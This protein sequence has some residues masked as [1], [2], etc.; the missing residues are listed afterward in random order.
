MKRAAIAIAILLSASLLEAQPRQARGESRFG[1]RDVLSKIG[2]NPRP[3]ACNYA[4]S[5]S[6]STTV[7]GMAS[8]CNDG[9]YWFDF[10]TFRA[11]STRVTA[12][13]TTGNWA[14]PLVV[15]IQLR[16]TGEIVEINYDYGSV[17]T[18]ANVTPGTDYVVSVGFLRERYSASYQVSLSCQ[19]VQPPSCQTLATLERGITYN[20]TLTTADSV[21]GS[22]YSDYL[23]RF[24]F[25]GEAGI[26]LRITVSTASFDPYME[27]LSAVDES[28]TW[29]NYDAADG[30]MIFYPTRTGEQILWVGNSSSSNR[31]EKTGA[32]SVRIDDEPLEACKRRAVRH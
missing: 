13:G 20:A 14:Y 31:N 21:C 5:I 17:S 1:A 30:Y 22:G 16:S 27:A 6:C 25:F 7:S 19:T 29:W 11:S 18:V 9:D 24:A 8:A 32:F 3:E 23:K 15:A 10:W 2:W 26:P 4:G 28:G 12:S